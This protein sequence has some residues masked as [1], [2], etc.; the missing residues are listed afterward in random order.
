LD[1][2][3][4][5]RVAFKLAPQAKNLHVDA[6]IENILMQARGLQ[7]VLAAERALWFR[8]FHGTAQN[9][10]LSG[11]PILMHSF[12]RFQGSQHFAALASYTD[13]WVSGFVPDKVGLADGVIE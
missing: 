10:G 4:C 9:D 5:A 3:R 13:E 1:D 6:A 2:A 8:F 11:T 12:G 7:Q